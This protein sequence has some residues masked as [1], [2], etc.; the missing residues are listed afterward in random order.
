MGL[1]QIQNM[2]VSISSHSSPMAIDVSC[3]LIVEQCRCLI[4]FCRASS[5]EVYNIFKR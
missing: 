4:V 2:H 5:D 3:Y 1:L